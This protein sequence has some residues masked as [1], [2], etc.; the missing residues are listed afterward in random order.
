MKWWHQIGLLPMWWKG[1]RSLFKKL[2]WYLVKKNQN[3]QHVKSSFPKYML[4][5]PLKKKTKQNCRKIIL[6]PRY[7]TRT[8]AI[9]IKFLTVLQYSSGVWAWANHRFFFYWSFYSWSFIYLTYRYKNTA[10]VFFIL[11]VEYLQH[12]EK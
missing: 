5:F 2:R 9:Y 6:S 8:S 4:K 11:S 3:T 7:Y 12:I 1:K 10:S